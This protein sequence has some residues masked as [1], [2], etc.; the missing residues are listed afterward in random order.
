MEH[1]LIRA[2]RSELPGSGTPGGGTRSGRV[3][4]AKAQLIEFTRTR[5]PGEFAGLRAMQVARKWRCRADLLPCGEPL[6]SLKA[7]G[8]DQSL[9]NVML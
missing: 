4:I 5:P 1:A 3:T 2:A 9:H 8:V 7:H 6:G